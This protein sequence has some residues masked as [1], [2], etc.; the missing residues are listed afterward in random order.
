MLVDPHNKVLLK[1]SMGA[2]DLDYIILNS[3]HHS[4]VRIHA[5]GPKFFERKSLVQVVAQWKVLMIA[6]MRS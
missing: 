4:F 6:T 1:T 3:F 5:D 2:E